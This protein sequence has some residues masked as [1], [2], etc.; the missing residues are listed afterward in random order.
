MSNILRRFFLH[1]FDLAGQ[2]LNSQDQFLLHLPKRALVLRAFSGQPCLVGSDLLDPCARPV[3][4]SSSIWIFCV[5]SAGIETAGS[6]GFV[7]AWR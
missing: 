4:R 7:A 5:I 2:L 6:I 3:S 1:G